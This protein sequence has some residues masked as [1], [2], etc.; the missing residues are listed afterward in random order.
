MDLLRVLG[1]PGG[2]ASPL[3]PDCWKVAALPLS[4]GAEPSGAAPDE[5]RLGHARVRVR[6]IV[7]PDWPRGEQLL[8]YVPRVMGSA[9]QAR[10]DGAVLAD[11]LDDWRMTWNR[12]A[13]AR[14]E[15]TRLRPGQTLDI[16]VGIAYPP[17]SGHSVSRITVGPASV[18]GGRLAWREYLQFTMPLA[19]SAVLLMIGAFF[20]AFWCARRLETAHL[21]LALA[22]VAWA[23]CNLQYVLPRRD[24][25]V[26]EAWYATIVHL[27][28]PWF[29]WLVYLFALRFDARRPRWMEWLLPL[30][31][32]AMNLVVV[33]P[34]LHVPASR[35]AGLPLWQ[36][37]DLGLAIQAVNSA[38][39]AGVTLLIGGLALRGGSV[40]LRVISVALVA[41]LAAGVHDVALLAQLV[42]PEGIYLLPYGGLLVFGAFL[43]AVQRRYVHAIDGH[44]ALSASLARRLA[45]REAELTLNHQRLR[46]L[47]RAQ[48]L[49]D[50]RQ[51]LMRD[52]HDGIGSALASSLV[53]VEHG[54]FGPEALAG[55]LRECVDDL[56]IVIDSLEP[57]DNDLVALLATLRFRIGPRLEAAGV[58]LGWFMQD[59]PALPW[60]G[61]SETLQV[62]RIVQEALAN[63]IKH[64]QARHLR[65]TVC[66]EP[67]CVRLRIEDDG[68]GFDADA[69]APQG[70][71]LRHM[72]QRA[73][74]LG[75]ALIIDSQS[76][77]GTR[78][79]LALPLRSTRPAAP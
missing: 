62:M 36:G 69:M 77:G 22:S 44:E 38:F 55:M 27:S 16:E 46:E 49:A 66:A 52:M 72:P 8:V 20:F 7:P 68:V 58:K 24:D 29:M 26:V 65:V 76:G 61:P 6:Y 34:L 30:H 43:F 41:A 11:N 54:E 35:M 73:A 56:R 21:L 9:W 1:Q 19:C 25:P 37:M 79:L 31:V 32:L 28:V 50:E 39:A 45:E 42:D 48:T 17:R 59:L 40:E 67:D 60:M 75:A 74:R 13:V 71:G 3:A 51:R 23:V 18:V 12:P 33:V 64:A 47:E 15:S 57:M 53:A 4:S 5:Q 78:V 10:V 14:V 70:R 2:H 63:V